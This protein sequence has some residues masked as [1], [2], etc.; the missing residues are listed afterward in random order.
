MCIRDRT[1]GISSANTLAEN[2]ARNRA[3]QAAFNQMI[4]PAQIKASKIT[5]SKITPIQ[6]TPAKITPIQTRPINITPAQISSLKKPVD[7]KD[8]GVVS[9]NRSKFIDPLVYSLN[10]DGSSEPDYI[11]PGFL[12]GFG[13]VIDGKRYMSEQEAIA[14]MG[15][16]R[17][18]MF[19]AEGGRV[20]YQ[21]GGISS[22]NTLAENIARNRAA[23]SAFQQ[24]IA[25]AQQKTRQTIASRVCLLYTSPSPRDGLLSRMPSSA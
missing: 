2:I 6:P 8:A 20:G 5:P 18:N 22:A 16:E 11:D 25:P 13:F 3:A 10:M 24:S 4:R 23:Q 21:T 9:F 19:M 1:G 12:G 14:D 15:V 17:Y 7:P